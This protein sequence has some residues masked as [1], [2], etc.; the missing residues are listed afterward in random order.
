[1]DFLCDGWVWTGRKRLTGAVWTQ[2]DHIRGRP[3]DKEEE[4]HRGDEGLIDCGRRE[5]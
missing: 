4:I 1:M 5:M 3:V 2:S